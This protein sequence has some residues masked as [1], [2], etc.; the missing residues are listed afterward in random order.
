MTTDSIFLPFMCNLRIL[1]MYIDLRSGTEHDFEILSFLIGS[2]SISLGCPEYLEFNIRFHNYTPF[3][4]N[5]FYV[6]LCNVW[7]RLDTITTYPTCSR[8]RGVHIS[9]NYMLNYQHDDEEE[10]HMGEIFKAIHYGLPLLCRKGILCIRTILGEDSESEPESIHD[11]EEMA[12]SGPM[13]DSDPEP[14][15]ED[16]EMEEVYWF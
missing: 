13:E 15:H 5:S 7:R 12:G 3:N 10:P 2:L 14:N 6:N 16:E 4:P 11:Y 9:I 8:L 1:Q